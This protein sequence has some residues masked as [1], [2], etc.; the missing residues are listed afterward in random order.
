ME[1]TLHEEVGRTKRCMRA[2][3]R[4]QRAGGEGQT[5]AF[6]R[7]LEVVDGVLYTMLWGLTQGEV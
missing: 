1:L 3:G 5:G 6:E 4:A 7:V 2:Y